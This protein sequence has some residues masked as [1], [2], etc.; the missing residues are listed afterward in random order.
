MSASA[1]ADGH[2][3]FLRRR[4]VLAAGRRDHAHVG[5]LIALIG[6]ITPAISASRSIATLIFVVVR[7]V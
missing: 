2:L 6:R 3:D 4:V 5:R 1:S 7:E